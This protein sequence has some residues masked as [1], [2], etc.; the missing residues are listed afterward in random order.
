MLKWETFQHLNYARALYFE[1]EGSEERA[2][3]SL[4]LKES[5]WDVTAVPLAEMVT[6]TNPK[7]QASNNAFWVVRFNIIKKNL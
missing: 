1:I 5:L 2:M 4:L 6:S 7:G 3:A